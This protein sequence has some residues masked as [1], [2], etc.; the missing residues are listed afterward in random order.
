MVKYVRDDGGSWETASPG[1]MIDNA[2]VRRELFHLAAA[3]AADCT[4]QGLGHKVGLWRSTQLWNE[5]AVEEISMRL[6]STASLLRARDDYILRQIARLNTDADHSWAK[7]L[8][9][10]P[11]GTLQPDLKKDETVSLTLREAC[12]KILHC[13]DYQFDL[14]KLGEP[15]SYANPILHLNDANWQAVLDIYRFIE[16]GAHYTEFS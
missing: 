1:A 9:E 15:D 16:I 13:H 8:R 12:N 2:I 5:F 10:T 6:A 7:E 3:F 14:E 4:M 11:C